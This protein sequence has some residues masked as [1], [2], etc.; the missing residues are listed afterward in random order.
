V[1]KVSNPI[2]SENVVENL[3]GMTK[4]LLISAA[5]SVSESSS[6]HSVY[7]FIFP[8]FGVLAYG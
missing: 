7:I 4:I 3:R 8:N 2:N 1:R 6:L 5:K